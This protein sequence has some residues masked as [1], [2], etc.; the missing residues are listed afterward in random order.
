MPPTC[1]AVCVG[2]RFIAR[3]FCPSYM[4]WNRPRWT[5]ASN[6]HQK[7][8]WLDFIDELTHMD[9]DGVCG[10]TVGHLQLS[11][12]FTVGPKLW[13]EPSGPFTI[14]LNCRMSTVGHLQ[15]A[16]KSDQ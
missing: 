6:L 3:E 5:D 14:G 11:G 10:S 1:H 13:N 9:G 7:R 4:F 2:L 8:T 16:L 12:S 15:F